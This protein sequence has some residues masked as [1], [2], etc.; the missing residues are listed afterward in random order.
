MIYYGKTG[1]L[2]PDD[3]HDL[4]LLLLP[5]TAGYVAAII[6]TAVDEQF[7]EGDKRV[8][9]LFYSVV[10][11][12][13]TLIFLVILFLLI[14]NIGPGTDVPDLRRQLVSIEIAFGAGFGIIATDL[15]GKIE[16][17]TVADIPKS[18]GS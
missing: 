6:R 7:T 4:A 2:R 8:V 18:H 5:V 17:V 9:N 16:R 1:W 15:F 10:V 12:L 13:V 14:I 3:R 11:I